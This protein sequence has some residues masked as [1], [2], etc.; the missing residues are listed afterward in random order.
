MGFVNSK[1]HIERLMQDNFKVVSEIMKIV[2]I[3]GPRQCGKTTLMRH[4][5]GNVNA[6][7]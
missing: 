6:F 5:L 7:A 4:M 1:N 2:L 3:C